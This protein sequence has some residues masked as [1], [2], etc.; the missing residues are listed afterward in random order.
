MWLLVG[1]RWL[2]V[3]FFFWGGGLRADGVVLLVAACGGKGPVGWTKGSEGGASA[4]AS[5]LELGLGR[6]G[7]GE[8]FVFGKRG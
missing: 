1:R 8:F 7:D 4:S 3:G 2:L 5:A 6:L